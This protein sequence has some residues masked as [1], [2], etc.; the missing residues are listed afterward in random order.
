LVQTIGKNQSA[1]LQSGKQLIS[2]LC[3]M[4]PRFYILLCCFMAWL[5]VTAQPPISSIYQHVQDDGSP[6]VKK[7]YG[8]LQQ[9]YQLQ[10][11]A[12]GLA[13]ALGQL[14]DNLVAREKVLLNM[15][16]SYTKQEE[17]DFGFYN[18]RLAVND[19]ET[20]PDNDIIKGVVFA[21]FGNYLVSR[22]TNDLAIEFLRRS[23]PILERYKPQNLEGAGYSLLNK[24]LRCFIKLGEMDSV[25]AYTDK[26][27]EHAKAYK[28]KIWLSSGYN[29]KGYRFYNN[30]QMDSAQ[31]YYLLAQACLNLAEGE[32]LLFYENINENIAHIHAKKKEYAQALAL[33]EKVV[34][35]RLQFPDKAI[36]AL[37]GLNYYTDYCT[38]AGQPA[39]ALRKFRQCLPLLQR[40]KD[41]FEN[42]SEYLRLQMKLAKLSGNT[43][44]YIMY[45]EQ[46]LEKEKKHLETEKQLLVSRKGLNKYIKSRNALFEQQL[47]I[48]K[49]QKAKL[50]QSV[51]YRNIFI[52]ILILL[53]GVVLYSIYASGK[54]KKKLLEVEN[55]KLQQ[56]EKI[57]DL[58]NINLKTNIELK[59]KDISRVVADNK[60]RTEMKKD[61][62]KKLEELQNGDEKRVKNEIRKLRSELGQTINQHG[63]LDLLQHNIEDI[64]AQFEAKLRAAIPTITQS[65]IEICSLI[66]L[67]YNN[68]EIANITNKTPENVRVNKFRIKQKAGLED[69]KEL[70][71]LI[72]EI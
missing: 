40:S 26:V 39:M 67:G 7:I 57:L 15:A 14:G 20:L 62:L 37:L 49:L 4:N 56:R 70:E 13:Q 10:T 18:L 12:K 29:N 61:F 24:M 17:E 42:S 1:I 68:T 28:D 5:N 31:R 8:L 41:G 46:L 23:I 52:I 38:K 59:E 69:M 6:V 2:F 54:Y 48:E 55:E 47:E 65:E 64:N 3:I 19:A 25:K 27:I 66:R 30:N 45:F 33:Q 11:N 63:K 53:S 35:T 58:E 44:Q 50:Q 43:A 9:F 36:A 32:H 21:E 34:D 71:R 51:S 60:L 22:E 72:K 16:L